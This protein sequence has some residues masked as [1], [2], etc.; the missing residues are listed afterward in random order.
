M[1][2]QNIEKELLG[3]DL[4]SRAKLASKLLQSLDDLSESE[5]EKLWVEEAFA[6]M[7]N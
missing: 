5:I 6:G 2:V 3:L 4:K 1:T 7:K